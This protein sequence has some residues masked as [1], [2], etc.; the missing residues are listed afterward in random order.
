MDSLGNTILESKNAALCPSGRWDNVPFSETLDMTN[1]ESAQPS[2][3]NKS[4]PKFIFLEWV[5]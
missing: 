4:F 1:W 2:N 3:T 5:V